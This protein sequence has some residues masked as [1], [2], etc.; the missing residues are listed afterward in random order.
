MAVNQQHTADVL[1]DGE[2]QLPLYSFF[3]TLKQNGFLVTPA[4]IVDSNAVIAEYAGKVNNEAEL[5]NYLSPLFANN[6]EEQVLF[7]KLYNQH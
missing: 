3:I 4:Q 2:L 5:C 1:Q 6:E 7:T